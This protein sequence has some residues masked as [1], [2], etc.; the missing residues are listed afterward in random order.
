MGDV[1]IQA[2]NIW[3]EYQLGAIQYGTLAK[4]MQSWWAKTRGREDPNSVIGQKARLEDS[5]FLALRDVSFEIKRGEAVGII[6]RNGAGKSTL[7]KIISRITSPTKGTI[8][9]RGRIASLLEIG[10]GFH[11]E[12]T[13]R[14]NIYLNGAI[15]GMTK[16][17]TKSKF[18]SIVDF[19]G[20]EDFI[21]T[22]V[23]RYSSGM[24]VRL[25]FAVAAHLEPEILIVDEVLAV[26]DYQFQ[27]KCLGKMDDISKEGRTVLLVSHSMA[28]ILSLSTK[29]LLLED[30]KLGA[31]GSPRDVVT[32][33]MES[34]RGGDAV[35]G[36]IDL[37]E[38]EHYGTGKAKFE[39]INSRY[40]YDSI[41]QLDPI[42]GCDIVFDIELSAKESINSANIAVTIYDDMG[43]RLIDVNS[44]IKGEG[45]SIQKN[46]KAMIRFVLKNVLLKPDTYIV[47]LWIGEANIEDMDGIRYATAFRVEARRE[48]ILY[49]APFP[50]VYSC[51]FEYKEITSS[52]G[53]I[54]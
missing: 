34:V 27:K 14:E 17:E 47:G 8:K 32:Q 10:T 43:N 31:F 29:C 46:Q 18:D 30:G 39:T 40:F 16:S 26:G 13:G 41:E 6:G 42:T 50:G 19:A 54:K 44:L 12:L 33:Y 25:A 52:K 22:P 23:K 1:I 53:W 38:A 15:L 9:M 36:R 21:D 48:D 35:V 3:K 7:L 28:S 45:V 51:E 4:S 20:I 5:R 2:E 24:Y 49:T 37:S 11:P